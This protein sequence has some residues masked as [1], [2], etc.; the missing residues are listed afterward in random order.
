[1]IVSN[2]IRTNI[3]SYVDFWRM[4][5][6]DYA[7]DDGDS[8]WF[9]LSKQAAATSVLSRP[10][11][12]IQAAVIEKPQPESTKPQFVAPDNWP[13]E[14][15]A[16]H[17]Q[18]A[19]G[20]AFPGNVYGR[21]IALPSGTINPELMILGDVPE[22]DDI[23]LGS[24]EKGRCGRMATAIA[25]AAGFEA[26][27]IYYS[28]LATTRPGTGALPDEH[29]EQLLAFFQ[30]CVG[31]IQPKM[32]LILGPNAAQMLLNADFMASRGNLLNINHKGGNVAAVTTFHPRTLLT[33]STLKSVVWQDLQM[34]AKRVHSE[35]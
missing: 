6:V 10:P 20:V 14:L 29:R 2:E 35:D 12:E 32:I 5:G 34:L 1:M 7:V 24:L 23:E 11:M 17:Q 26:N 33:N 13:Q 30:H 16:L 3:D 9:E 22:I 31:I 18:I 8:N 27:Q 4:S 28:A 25:Q 19:E 15:D 21:Q